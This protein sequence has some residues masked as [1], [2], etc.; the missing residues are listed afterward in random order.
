MARPAKRQINNSVCVVPQQTR[1]HQEL[2]N[3]ASKLSGLYP[4][5]F[6]IVEENIEFGRFWDNEVKPWVGREAPRVAIL[7][8]PMPLD[9]I[10]VLSWRSGLIE[11][12]DIA[13]YKLIMVPKTPGETGWEGWLQKQLGDWAQSPPEKETTGLHVKSYVTYGSEQ[14]DEAAGYD[15]AFLTITPGGNK[16]TAVL[17]QLDKCKQMFRSVIGRK[18]G[19]RRAEVLKAVGELVA[20]NLDAAKQQRKN[21]SEEIRRISDNVKKAIDRNGFHVDRNRLPRVL[22]LGPSG[23]GKTLV[24]RY[25]A[26]R[27]SPREGEPKSRPFKRV[28]IPEYLHKEDNFEYDIFG[29]CDGAYSGARPGGSLGYLLERMGGVVFFDEIG[30]ASP[31]IQAKLL[32]YLDDYQVTPRGWEGEPVYCP[33]LVVAA[34]NRPID[35]WIEAALREEKT[36]QTNYFRNDLF[37]RFNFIIRIPPLNERRG[38]IPFI[39]DAMLQMEAFNPGKKIREIGQQ[40]LERIQNFDYSKGNF[41]TLENLLRSACH[42]AVMDGRDYLVVTDCEIATTD[43]EGAT[44]DA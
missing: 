43:S 36:D 16:M 35:K 1:N 32:A 2:H 31:V 8:C 13:A 23:V 30:E 20:F 6:V 14:Y 9:P 18:V 7:W 12:G 38:E 21:I 25:L 11:E 4:I 39:L 28:P 44:G 17:E 34:T 10:A 19:E 41:R 22:L 29:Y 40:A 3:A 15:P 26:W 24:A 27:T 33:M 5:F 37:Q 42:K